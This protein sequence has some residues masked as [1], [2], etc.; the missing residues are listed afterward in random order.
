MLALVLAALGCVLGI[1]QLRAGGTGRFLLG[2]GAVLFVAVVPLAEKLFRPAPYLL[3]CELFAFCILAY[4]VGCVYQAF[5]K[6]PGLDKASH[7]LSGFVFTTLGYCLYLWLDARRGG[8]K[9]A[10]PKQHGGW[11]GAGWALMFSNLVAVLWEVCEFVGYLL[12]GHDSQ[13]TLTTG[14]FDTM[15]DLIACMVA[16]ILCFAMVV[17]Y[18]ARG[19]KLVTGG[20]VEEFEAVLE[21][22]A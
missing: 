11:L 22:K 14:V 9:T 5:D 17:L 4:D 8:S 19:V 3:L 12:T 16:S 21:K 18:R 10:A 13:H 15:G 6:V 20:I 2:L 1:L 7:F